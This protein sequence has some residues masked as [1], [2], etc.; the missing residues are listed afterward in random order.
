V[1][2]LADEARALDLPSRTTTLGKIAELLERNGIDVDDVGRV[3]RMNLWQ[4]GYVDKDGE[5]QAVDLVGV[6]LSPAW[7]DGPEWPVVAPAAPVTAKPRPA[8]KATTTGQTIIIAPDPQIGFRRYEDGTLD[9]FH[10]ERAIAVMLQIVRDAKPSRIV[11][12]GDTCDF[13]EWSSK[14]LVS[15]EFVLTTQPTIDRTHR[16]LAEQITEA[17]E[18]CAIDM[19]EGNHDNRLPIAITK[20]AM[21]AL[22]L[23][24]ANTP[25]SWPVLSLQ[26]LLR[27][28]ELGVDYRDGY[29]A[30]RVKLADGAGHQTPLYAIHG[31]RLTVSAVAKN[32]RQSFVQGH[33]HRIQDHYETYEVDGEPVIVNAWSPGCL[34]RVDGSIPSTKGGATAKGYPVR[35]WENWTQGIGVVTVLPDGTWEKEI[36]PIRDGRAIWRGKEYVSG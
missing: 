6:Q 18:G 7:A 13:P 30:G 23:R 25:E 11:N 8:P 28:D 5:A 29:P 26:H 33:I 34:S 16:Y 35:R 31:E 9:P 19:L 22:R 4:M 20:N 32:E 12:L 2:S 15:P 10:D 17:P 14:F 1:V 27:L 24:Q 21:A 36:V 3:Q